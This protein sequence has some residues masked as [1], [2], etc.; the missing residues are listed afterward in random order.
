LGVV[1]DALDFSKNNN[2]KLNFINNGV[3]GIATAYMG[4]YGYSAG[5][6]ETVG[7]SLF[8]GNDNLGSKLNPKVNKFSFYPNTSNFELF[9]KDISINGQEISILTNSTGKDHSYGVPYRLFWDYDHETIFNGTAHDKNYVPLVDGWLTK[10][11]PSRGAWDKYINSSSTFSDTTNSDT[12][13]NKY[14]T[15]YV[16]GAMKI[17][18]GEEP[19]NESYS[20][21]NLNPLTYE[22]V[23]LVLEKD[24]LTSVTNG[25]IDE[26]KLPD[27]WEEAN[28]LR[29]VNADDANKDSDNDGLTNLEEYNNGTNSTDPQNEDSDGDGFKD[30]EEVTA[31]TNP[32]DILDYPY[33]KFSLTLDSK[34]STHF[35]LS[36][37]APT[38]ATK[39]KLCQSSIDEVSYET[40]QTCSSLIGGDFFDSIITASN[41]S[42]NDDG[43][44]NILQQ[45]TTYYFRVVAYNDS[46]EVVGVS[47]LI[48]DKLAVV[49]NTETNLTNG[50]VAHYKFE[51]QNGATTLV[52]SSGNGNDGT[53]YGGVEFV[54]GVD[55]YIDSNSPFSNINKPTLSIS[56]WMK[57]KLNN[58]TYRQWL[59]M[60]NHSNAR[61]SVHVILNQDSLHIAT[62]G[63]GYSNDGASGNY[64]T[65][66][67]ND[68]EWIHI[69]TVYDR[70][71]NI[72]KTYK[73]NIL[74]DSDDLSSDRLFLS[75]NGKIFIA[76]AQGD[77]SLEDNY[78]GLIDDLRIYNRALNESEIKELYE[79]GSLNKNTTLIYKDKFNDINKSFWYIVRMYGPNGPY[80]KNN[81]VDYNS[82]NISNGIITLN[83]DRTD[84]GPVMYSKPIPVK[85]GDIITITRKVY[86]HPENRYFTGSL[87]IVSSDNTF[88]IDHNETLATIM[89]YDYSY[90]GDWN[91]FILNDRDNTS[92]FLEPIWNDWF[93]ETLK[94]NTLTG[95][96]IYS[97]NNKAVKSVL[98]LG[99]RKTSIPTPNIF[100]TFQKK[101]KTNK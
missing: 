39:Y 56:Y 51:E 9:H 92:N 14:R 15:K 59:L 57:A 86:V 13:F 8:V 1:E 38:E 53:I 55:D 10:P 42:F 28:G 5:G 80:W 76:K 37:T 97:I 31:G 73:N 16:Q 91:T 74:V 30:G 89:H 101:Y 12:L 69:T 100:P 34:T 17:R 32:N 82:V 26:D 67:D 77:L 19:N 4:S 45:D 49:D 52:D 2:P 27:V 63:T 58:S 61:E 93:I 64:F 48:S 22:P 29:W 98:K 94:Y 20:A 21:D 23:F 85:K 47:S 62:W 46:D 6:A 65:I 50:L 70:A 71:N 84:D 3:F 66:N 41:I 78:N 36:W 60:F 75:S 54:D 72:V 43:L 95:E 88:S 79:M 90:R 7:S 83:M 81:V 87:S 24:L 99:C 44:G 25:D 40:A 35:N 11:H 68:N 96:S 18:Y 33:V